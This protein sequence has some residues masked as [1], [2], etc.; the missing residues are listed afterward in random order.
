MKGLKHIYGSQSGGTSSGSMGPKEEG[1]KDEAGFHDE[2]GDISGRG[3]PVQSPKLESGSPQLPGFH[4][5][6]GNS[7]GAIETLEVGSPIPS[8]GALLPTLEGGKSDSR[9]FRGY[10]G[11][12][13]PIETLEI[14]SMSPRDKKVRYPHNAKQAAGALK[15]RG[16][17]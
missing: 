2:Y 17:Y 4:K 8:S 15:M 7:G 6:Y 1:G 12:V 9:F 10:G 16:G 13:G 11:P 14:G 5:N 3:G